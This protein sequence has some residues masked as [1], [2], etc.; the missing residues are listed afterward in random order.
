MTEEL[1]IRIYDSKS[2]EKKL[3]EVGARFVDET[4]FVDTYFN[5][6]EGKVLKVVKKNTGYFLNIFHAVKGKFEVVKD[7][8]IKNPEKK[9]MELLS[10]YGIKC[11]LKGK[12]KF[13]QLQNY[14]ITFN[15]I[16][17]VGKFLII[18]GENPS[19]SFVEKELGIEK[20]EYINVSFDA[21]K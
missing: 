7:Q 18:T 20:P 6:P 19:K 16:D 2:M 15:L 10:Q 17:N 1:K 8:Q 13:F 3:L 5:Q 14:K 21:L 4:D 12:R 9:K 11:V